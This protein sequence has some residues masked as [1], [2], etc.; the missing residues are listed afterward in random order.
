MNTSP[1]EPITTLSKPVV[2]L[3]SHTSRPR[4][5]EDHALPEAIDE[6]FANL[7]ARQERIERGV[8]QSL[9]PAQFRDTAAAMNQQR[10]RL[11]QL[12]RDIEATPTTSR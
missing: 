11:A 4:R 8:D 10:E 3:P 7:A 12:L 2:M 5:R 1:F 9:N 6:V